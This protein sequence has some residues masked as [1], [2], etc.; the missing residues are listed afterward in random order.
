MRIAFWAITERRFEDGLTTI[1]HSRNA[2]D[3]MGLTNHPFEEV[4][5]GF[6]SAISVLVPLVGELL[7]FIP[8]VDGFLV[9]RLASLL[10]FVATIVATWAI[11]EYFGLSR[12]ARVLA[13]AYLAFS[14][15]QFFYGIGGMETQMAVAI[16]LWAVVAGLHARPV[17]AG[18][19]Y[20]LCLLARPDFV[21]FIGP[22]LVWWLV[23]DR[24]AVL[25][26][27]A[28]TG[29]VLL[30]WVAFTTLYYG[31][32]VPN[33]LHAK[34]LRYWIDWPDSLSPNAWWDFLAI[35]VGGREPWLWRSLSPFWEHSFVIDAPVL[36]TVATWFSG[37]LILLAF[38]GAIGLWRAFPHARPA[39][40]FVAMFIPYRL[41]ALPAGYYD[42]YYPPLTAL[43]IIFVAYAVDRLSA[44]SPRIPVVAAL[45]VAGGFLVA[46][47]PLIVL[48]E[49]YQ[50]D[51]EDQV[52]VPL[53]LYLRDHV[54]RGSVVTSESAGYV[55]YYS[56]GNI[57]LWDYPGLTSKEALAIL[58][59]LGPERSDLAWLVHAGHPDYAVWRPD[60]LARF[61][62]QF[63]DSAALYEEVA[64]FKAPVE[65]RLAWA[66]VRF[67]V[68]DDDFIVARRAHGELGGVDR[69][70]Q[71]VASE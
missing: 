4:T 15:T 20:G 10:A 48:E 46:V 14:F 42:W 34:S 54:P 69:A 35:N 43:I 30:P 38:A 33:T 62:G 71:L 66:G 45:V 1:T 18:L 3:G 61:E 21:L 44:V 27:G 8:G 29:A 17:A 57:K 50:H 65:D 53:S 7:S 39:I 22:A 67:V 59:E 40:V 68:V 12:W 28:L 23:R 60:E 47:P 16:L 32:P 25:R 2:A 52:R 41:I 6:T 64:R 58:D 49:R 9:I 56:S 24:R 26:V 11:T 31:S 63:P 13:Y 51:V 19:L 5:H 70:R 37:T 55:G 36:Q